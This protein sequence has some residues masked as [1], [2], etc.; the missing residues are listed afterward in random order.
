MF[1]KFEMMCIHKISLY[2]YTVIKGCDNVRVRMIATG[3]ML[4]DFQTVHPH[5]QSR[6]QTFKRNFCHPYMIIKSI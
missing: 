3:N 4:Q 2:M 6:P 5:A 1:E